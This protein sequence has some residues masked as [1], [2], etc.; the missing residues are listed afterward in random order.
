VRKGRGLMGKDIGKK[1][2][3]PKEKETKRAYRVGRM[4]PSMLR[5][6]TL[7][8]ECLLLGMISCGYS[9]I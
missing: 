7:P 2:R 3:V 6:R 9:E 5:I 4:L 8:R 1:K